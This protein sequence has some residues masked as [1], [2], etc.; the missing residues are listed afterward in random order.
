MPAL[1]SCTH[2]VALERVQWQQAVDGGAISQRGKK[3]AADDKTR[4]L[5]EIIRSRGCKED[6]V[7]NP[8]LLLDGLVSV[9]S[10]M[11][12]RYH[13]DITVS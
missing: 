11:L 9:Y 8:T 7:P 1:Y 5:L 6:F 10:I 12:Y 2:A 3:G 4:Q 13:R